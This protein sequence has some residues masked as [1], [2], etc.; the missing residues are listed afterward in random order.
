M[1]TAELSAALQSLNSLPSRTDLLAIVKQY[2]SDGSGDLSFDEFCSIFDKAKLR[3]VFTDMDKDGSDEIS[4]AELTHALQSLGHHLNSS[5]IFAILTKVDADKSGEISYAEFEEFFKY[6]PAASLASI[7]KVWLDFGST[8]CGSDLAPCVPAPGV[9]WYYAVLGGLG[10]VL[11]R[12]LTAPL[13]KVKLVAQTS[14]ARVSVL[15]E[16]AKTYKSLGVRGLFAGNAANC[17][18][19]FPCAGIVTYTY[20]S[21]LKMTPADNELDPME[22]VYRGGCAAV[23]GIMVGPARP[24]RNERHFELSY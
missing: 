1:A 3:K 14:T 9:P 17:I 13:E 19:V 20:L 16:L 11:S 6:V 21:L 5:Q 22:P 12:T 18:R 10:G 7:A 2:D 23:A 8:D 4:T 15:T 24:A